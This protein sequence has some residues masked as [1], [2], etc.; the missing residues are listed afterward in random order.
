MNPDGSAQT[1][2][3][4]D[5]LWDAEP[6]WS[7]DGTKIAFMQYDL[8]TLGRELWVM[9]RDGSNQEQVTHSGDLAEVLSD[10]QPIPPP[11]R[12]DYKNAAEFCVA[13][14][15]FFGEEEFTEKYGVNG[16]GANAYGN[17]VSQSQ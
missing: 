12:S 16:N 2:L 8:Q 10:W 5:P 6:E 1:R 7:P 13:A 4:T 9:N 14:R 3:T 15:D 11:K 17:C